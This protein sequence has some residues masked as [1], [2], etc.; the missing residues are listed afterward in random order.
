MPTTVQLSDEKY[1]EALQFNQQ[2]AQ[3]I[4]GEAELDFKRVSFT[5]FS[6]LN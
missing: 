4:I 1:Q 3:A 2:K 6:H 5:L